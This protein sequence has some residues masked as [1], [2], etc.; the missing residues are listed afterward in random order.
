LNGFVKFLVLFN[1]IKLHGSVSWRAEGK[2]IELDKDLKLV[3]E[4]QKFFIN[5]DDKFKENYDKLMIVNLYL[6]LNLP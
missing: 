1:I 3:N 5:E 2:N 4:I 6:G